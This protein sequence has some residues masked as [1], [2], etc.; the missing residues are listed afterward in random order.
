[1]GT[2][3]TATSKPTLQTAHQ[4]A[5]TWIDRRLEVVRAEMKDVGAALNNAVERKW[6]TAALE[7]AHGKLVA[8][9]AFLMKVQGAIRAGYSI[10]PNFNVR[11]LAVRTDRR[12]PQQELNGIPRVGA[13]RLPAGAGQFVSP[14]P[15]FASWEREYQGKDGKQ[16]SVTV[17]QATEHAPVDIPF[18]LAKGPLAD[19]LNQALEEKIFDEIGIVQDT[20][21]GDPVLV[22]RIMHPRRMSRWDN[23]GVTFFIG[24]WLDLRTLER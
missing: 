6:A 23:A 2:T 5:A 16:H 21:R 9:E 8:H 12:V 1:M 17:Y 7:R 10:V 13:R 24:W 15:E 20:P 3:L 14:E 11:L 4:E 22:G 18:V 19:A